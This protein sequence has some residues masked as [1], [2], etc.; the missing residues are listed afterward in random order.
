MDTAHDPTSHLPS[1]ISYLISPISHLLLISYLLS[2]ISYLLS[3]A[4]AATIRLAAP[5]DGAFYDLHSPCVKEFL[6]HW[7]ERGVKPPRP[8][9]TEEEL[10]QSNRQH[11][12]YL[13]WRAAGSPKDKRVK[14]WEDRFNFYM[15]NSWSRELMKRESEEVKTYKPFKWTVEGGV[16]N[17]VVE[18]STTPDFKTVLTEKI[19]SEKGRYFTS[20]RPG[21]LLLGTKYWW[22][23]RAKDRHDGGEVL[24]DVRTFTTSDKPP[25]MIGKPLENIRDLGGGVNADGVPVRQGL[26][27]RGQAPWARWSVASLRDRYVKKL[28]VRTQ[29]DLRGRDE[30][31]ARSA[32]WGETDLETVGVR[33][34]FITIIP[35]HVYYPDNLPK[36]REMFTLLACET[37]YPVYFNCAVGSDRTGTLAFLLDGVIGREDRYFYDDY[38]LPSF[39]ENLKRYRYCRKGSELFNLFAKGDKPIRENVVAYLLKIGVKQEE[40][41]AIRRIML[42]TEVS[43]EHR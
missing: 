17:V 5:D 22:R 21:Y 24:S 10:A 19:G 1:P 9:L 16:S 23:V 13:K 34:V 18:F 39:N 2:P 15:H 41:D 30:F 40:I 3:A 25:R 28:G 8:K 37:N 27:Y 35:Y 14:D 32:R 20:M 26:L 29:L 38:E 6:E 11:N 42:N 36:F 12:A 7:E 31:E 4:S 33:H 43:A